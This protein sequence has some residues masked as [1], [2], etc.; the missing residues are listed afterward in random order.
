MGGK[1]ISSHEMHTER[2]ASGPFALFSPLDYKFVNTFHSLM[3]CFNANCDIS[4]LGNKF[5]IDPYRD[6][7][8]RE[9]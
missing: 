3:E 4:Y 8:S 7:G 6:I 9:I 2:N 5:T 1:I